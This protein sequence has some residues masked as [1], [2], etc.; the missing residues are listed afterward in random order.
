M[1]GT[2]EKGGAAI[3]RGRPGER[4]GRLKPTLLSAHGAL[5]RSGTQSFYC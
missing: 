4:R 2:E 3:F 1:S 5:N